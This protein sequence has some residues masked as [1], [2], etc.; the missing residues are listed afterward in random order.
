MLVHVGGMGQ[1]PG[2]KKMDEHGIDCR[3]L[4]EKK[5]SIVPG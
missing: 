2:S 4:G 3:G 1:G 5:P